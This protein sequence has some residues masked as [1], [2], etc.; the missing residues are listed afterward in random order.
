M[1]KLQKTQKLAQ[2]ACGRGNTR[3]VKERSG[4]AKAEKKGKEHCPEAGAGQNTDRD[5]EKKK[6]GTKRGP[7]RQKKEARKSETKAREKGKG[8]VEGQETEKTPRR[9][10]E[11]KGGGK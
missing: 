6:A 11:K 3:S 1:G 9:D 7:F 4:R 2:T 5:K 10:R 8:F